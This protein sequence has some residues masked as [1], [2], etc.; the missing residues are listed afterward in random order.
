MKKSFAVIAVLLMLVSNTFAAGAFEGH[1]NERNVTVNGYD[2]SYWSVIGND[3]PGSI[4][5][6]TTVCVDLDAGTDSVP[7]GYLGGQARLY[8]SSGVLKKSSEWEYNEYSK[9]AMVLPLFSYSASSGYYYSK[10][11]ARFYTGD[12]YVTY[13]CTATPNY[14]PTKSINSFS[15]MTIQRNENGEIYGSE[16]FLNEIGVQPDLILAE[17]SNG[18]IG[19]VRAEDINDSSVTTPQEAMLKMGNGTTSAIPLY[20]SDGITVIGSFILEP[21]EDGVNE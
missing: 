1:S 21:V 11:Q 2:Y 20:S 19:Y 10:G 6:Q 17:G 12:G 15:S 14:A 3:S 5:T 18:E 4:F 16:I 7:I 13:A 8:S 9:Y